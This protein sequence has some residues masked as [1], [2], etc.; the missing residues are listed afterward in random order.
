MSK[1]K[2]RD[3]QE[4]TYIL[5][6]QK[7]NTEAIKR[8][9]VSLDSA[10]K[11]CILGDEMV[12]DLCSMYMAQIGE[13]VKQLTDDTREKLNA[14]IDTKIL[15]YFRNRIDHRYEKINKTILL[16][17]IQQAQSK[18]SQKDDSFYKTRGIKKLRPHFFGYK[19]PRFHLNI[20]LIQIFDQHPVV[21]I[22][23]TKTIPESHRL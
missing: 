6:N 16:P 20:N 5:K 2:Q 18:E 10:A 7:K 23:Y 9:N 13:S 21:L 22:W 11:N 15:E 17:Y 8:M 19:I 4:L 12:F 1:S 3:I 14:S